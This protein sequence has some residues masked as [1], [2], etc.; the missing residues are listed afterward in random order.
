MRIPTFLSGA[1]A[2]LVL[3]AGATPALA[4]KPFLDSGA[5]L[6]TKDPY[7]S[8]QVIPDISGNRAVYGKLQGQTP[9]DIYTFTPK[10][11]GEQTFGLLIRRSEVQELSEPTLILIDPTDATTA[12]D[13]GIPLPGQENEY[14]S[15]VIKATEKNEDTKEFRT[16]NEPV[17]MEQFALVAEQAV[18][19]K[20]DTKYYLIVLDPGQRAQYYAIR[21]GTQKAWA[22]SDFFSSFGSWWKVKLGLYGTDSEFS[23]SVNSLGLLLFWIGFALLMGVWMLH[24][25]FG[26]LSV[27][28]RSAAY[29]LVKLQPYA[30]CTIWATLWFMLVGGYIYVRMMSFSGLVFLLTLLFVYTLVVMLITTFKLS[31]RLMRA[32]VSK[33][34]AVLPKDDQKFFYVTLILGKL[35]LVALLVFTLMLT[36]R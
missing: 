35:G 5:Q 1:L 36:A 17:L 4:G 6:D 20:K 29:L 3:L 33:K 2:A 9:V 26:L 34:E 10:E 16:Y 27:K 22:F 11:D 31:P 24:G 8:A 15:A 18:T 12:K 21:L 25:L 32:E 28:Q 23:F 7:K 13:L 30:R 19:L 14:H